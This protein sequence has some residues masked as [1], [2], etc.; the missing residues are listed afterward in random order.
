MP[1]PRKPTSLKLLTG[2]PGKRALPK[3][4]PQPAV[5]AERPPWLGAGAR[6]AWDALAPRLTRLRVLTELDA[7]ALGVLCLLLVE[8]RNRAR[9]GQLSSK[10]AAEVR[11]YLGKFGMTPADR[12]RVQAVP[13][14]E[15]GGAGPLSEFLRGPS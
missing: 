3:H 7:E 6:A 9:N 10:L 14:A 15:G 2:N 11:A 8:F 12:S 13:I 4:E 1:M 5:G